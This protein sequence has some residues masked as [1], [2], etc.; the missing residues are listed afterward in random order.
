MRRK[1]QWP[2]GNFGTENSQRRVGTHSVRFT[3]S[4]HPRKKYSSN[5]LELLAVVRSIDR[6]KHYLLG[7]EFT[8]ATDHKALTSALAE[9]RS[10]KTYQSQLTRC[11]DRLL[12]YQFKVVHIPGRDMGIVDYLSREANEEPW[13]ESKMDEKFV[14]ASIEEFH[15]TFD[16]LNS[17]L[18]NET[19]PDRNK[20]VLEHSGKRNTLDRT[21]DTSSHGCYSNQSVQKRIKLDRNENDQNSCLTNCI[22]NSSSKISQCKQSVDFTTNNFKYPEEKQMERQ[23]GKEKP[24]KTV[25]IIERKTNEGRRDQILEQV[26]ETTFQRTSTVHRGTSGE[27]CRTARTQIYRRSNGRKWTYTTRKILKPDHLRQHQHE[28]NHPSSCHFGI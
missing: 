19:Q 28:Q 2:G 12:P 6:F 1:S 22:R 21:Q 27:T 9:N 5:E 4:E 23:P 26:T 18:S 15:R 11:V 10:N 16:C 24:K 20:E 17:R 25:K 14:V 3:L 13:P 8:I 7:K